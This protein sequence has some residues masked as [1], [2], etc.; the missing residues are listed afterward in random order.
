MTSNSGAKCLI[1]AA[2]LG[3][4]LRTKGD[5][6]PLVS[7]YGI[8]LIERVM[9]SALVGG[10]D[11][12]IVVSGYQG[13]K[14]RAF[15][16]VLAKTLNISMTHVINDEYEKGNGL[17]VLKAKSVLNGPFLLMMSDHLFDPEIVREL[18]TYRDDTEA[19]RLAVDY[20]IDNPMIDLED[21]TRV[22][23]SGQG[24]IK[25]IGKEMAHYNC[26]DTGIFLCTPKLFEA[27]ESALESGND[28]L[29][30]GVEMLASEGKAESFDIGKRFWLDVDDPVAYGKAQ[31]SLQQQVEIELLN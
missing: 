31:L 25:N 11:E 21:V 6:K 8:P 24:K 16:D 28:S 1:I 4:R 14:L 17:S 3:S 18:L 23:T 13:D 27:L 9:R 20:G 29:S 15:L 12:F 22:F 2:G 7:L 10:A 30:G 5:I 26:F 19:L